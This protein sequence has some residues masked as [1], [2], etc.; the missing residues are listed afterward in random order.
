MEKEKNSNLLMSENEKVEKKQYFGLFRQIAEMPIGIEHSLVTKQSKSCPPEVFLPEGSF[1]LLDGWCLALRDE[2][3]NA[4]QVGAHSR[5]GCQFHD[6]QLA[7]YT[8][9]KVIRREGEILNLVV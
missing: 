1:L 5:I 4:P 3:V 9:E 2:M 8:H 6:P 7:V